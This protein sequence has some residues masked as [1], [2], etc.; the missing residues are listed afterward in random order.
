MLSRRLLVLTYYFP[1]Q[2]VVGSARWAAMSEWLRRLGHT[3]TVVT[4]CLGQPDAGEEESVMRT[5]DLAA[6]APAR[7]LLRRGS[8]PGLV[9]A[10]GG[11]VRRPMS[12]WFTDVLVP[13]EF[14]FTW[15]LPALT[16]VRQLIATE[17]FDCIITSGPPH[18]THLLALMLGRSRPAWIVDLRDAW[19]FDSMRTS[20]PT[21]AQNRL[22]SSLE[23]RVLRN[24]EIVVGVTRPIAV[25]A[26]ARVG[27]R[28]AYVPNGWDPGS[29][30]ACRFEE[31]ASG[32]SLSRDRLNL[33]YTGGLSGARGLGRDPRPFF[34]ALKRLAEQRP[35]I[36]ERI[37]VV[38]AGTLTP[39]EKAW[40]QETDFGVAVEHRGRVSR[41]AAVALQR[42]SDALLL[43]TSST[44]SSEATAKLFEYLSAGRPIM[45]LASDNEAAR[46]VRETGTGVT[47]HPNDV[48][49]IVEALEGLVDGTLADAY[50][51]HGL[52][53]YTYPW[54]AEELASLVEQAIDEHEST[55]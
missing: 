12:R 1:P 44:K 48:Q 36:A 9:E 42:S 28:V 49:A 54:L 35:A 17:S 51:P 24:A 10:G 55:R 20:W 43:I 18:S 52:E 31:N 53:R 27:A 3:V 22:D 4:S 6:V 37:R 5:F 34:D 14:L 23:R 26:A 13:D 16:R 47:V 40:L 19:G 25:D 38:L 2:P 45:A 33:V 29:P 39:E 11:A 50:A 15:S 21:G 8:V 7:N 30:H 32:E 46:I 41:E